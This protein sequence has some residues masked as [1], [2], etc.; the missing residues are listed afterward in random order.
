MS[1]RPTPPVPRGFSAEGDGRA[2]VEAS[3]QQPVLGGGVR[4][5]TV[6]GGADGGPLSKTIRKRLKP[7]NGFR[8]VLKLKLNKT[9]R[10]ILNAD[11]RLGVNVVVS[12]TDRRGDTTRTSSLLQ[13]LRRAR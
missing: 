10:A 3:L 4:T 6:T 9:G 13:L 8:R 12:V 11:G 5:I 7:K 1:A 2:S